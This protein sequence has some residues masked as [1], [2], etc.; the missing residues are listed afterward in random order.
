MFKSK[1]VLAVTLA[2]VAGTSFAAKLPKAVT[3][4]PYCDQVN[5]ITS[6]GDGSY[7]ANWDENAACSGAGFDVPA[8]GFR[9][10]K[11]AG[12]GWG[13]QFGTASYPAYALNW[14]ITLNTDGTYKIIDAAGYVALSGTWTPAIAGVRGTGEPITKSLK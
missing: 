12:T 3:L 1:I 14:S 9:G 11:L 10:G 8:Y 4:S 13:V 7:T 2:L 6:N 5:G